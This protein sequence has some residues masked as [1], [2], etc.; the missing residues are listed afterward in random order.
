MA[1]RLE[2]ESIDRIWQELGAGRKRRRPSSKN[3]PSAPLNIALTFGGE[4]GR[5]RG[6]V[7]LGNSRATATEISSNALIQGVLSVQAVT[8]PVLNSS[9]FGC[10]PP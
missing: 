6:G 9:I 2:H 7:M 10:Y 8:P 1:S 4:E 3:P 5:R